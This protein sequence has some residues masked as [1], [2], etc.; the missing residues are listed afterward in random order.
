MGNRPEGVI[1]K[2]E[3][4]KEEEFESLECMD[5]IEFWSKLDNLVWESK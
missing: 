5:H 3:V 2:V 1:R 4:E